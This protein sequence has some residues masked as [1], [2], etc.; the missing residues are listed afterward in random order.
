MSQ[1]VR[2]AGAR[3]DPQADS[4][5]VGGYTGADITGKAERHDIFFH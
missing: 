3:F 2:R 1:A 4:P 5:I